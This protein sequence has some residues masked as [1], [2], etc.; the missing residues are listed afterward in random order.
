MTEHLTIIR[1]LMMEPLTVDLIAMRT[2]WSHRRIRRL[3]Q[4]A[5]MAGF[6]VEVVGHYSQGAGKPWPIYRIGA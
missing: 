1:W 4:S 2:K 5:A 3:I 6:N